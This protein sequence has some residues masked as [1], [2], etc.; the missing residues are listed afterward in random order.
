M[1]EP[2]A[3]RWAVCA[4]GV[5]LAWLGVA[6]LGAGFS[7]WSG[8]GGQRREGDFVVFVLVYLSQV[9]AAVI[10]VCAVGAG[11]QGYRRPGVVRAGWRMVLA[12]VA[13]VVVSLGMLFASIV[14]Y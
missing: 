8:W 13:G 4:C 6:A 1:G 7:A 10:A 9:P 14:R 5:G 12:G 2:R 11:V 3:S